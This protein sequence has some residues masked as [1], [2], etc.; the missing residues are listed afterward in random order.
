M[1]VFAVQL[2]SRMPQL[3]KD[4]RIASLQDEALN[5]FREAVEIQRSRLPGVV[6]R[7]LPL[8]QEFETLARAVPPYHEDFVSLAC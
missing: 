3:A 8:T 2:P 6:A 5:A 4:P 1:G 7:L